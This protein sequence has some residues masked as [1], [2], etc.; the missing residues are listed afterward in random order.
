VSFLGFHHD[1]DSFMA[2]VDFL[3]VPS[4]A[5]ESFGMVIL[6]AMKH[7]KAVICTDFGGMKEVVQD[8]VTGLVVPAGDAL[9]LSKAMARLVADAGLRRQMGEGG[10]RRLNDRFTAE[11]MAD[12]YDELALEP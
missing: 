9:A 11:K 1:V 3:V 6:E 4:I 5:F 10:Y 8:G 2:R 7:R 12:Q